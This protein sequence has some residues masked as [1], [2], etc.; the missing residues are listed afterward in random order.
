MLLISL[1]LI[2]LCALACFGL[3]RLVPTRRLGQGAAAISGLAGLL[4]LNRPAAVPGPPETLLTIG[5]AP[6]QLSASLPDLE[7]ALA[8]AALGGGALALLALASAI[9][10]KVRGFGAI[11]GW[12][13]LALAAALLGLA[14]PPLSLLQPLAWTCGVIAGYGAIWASGALARSEALPQGLLLGLIGSALLGGGLVGAEPALAAGELPEPALALCLLLAVL[15][16][17][18]LAPFHGAR[19]EATAAPAPLGALISGLV[20]PC[21]G[22]G[23]LIR[24][25]PLLP[26]VPPSWALGLGAL[27]LMGALGSAGGALGER[28]LR[29]LLAWLTGGQ[30]GLVLIAAGLS[31]PLAA[32]AG[33]ALLLTMM[34]ASVAGAA[35]IEPL[36]R[37]AGTDD[38]TSAAPG[39]PLPLAGLLWAGAVAALL[40]LP[41]FLGFWGQIWLL[42]GVTALLPWA[43]PLLLAAGVLRLLAAL[44]P[45]PRFW[46]PPRPD[47]A[48][49]PPGP[50]DVI[51]GAAALMPP[52]IFGLAPQVA[53]ALWLRA[54]PFAPAALPIADGQQLAATLGAALIALAAGLI[55]RAPSARSLSADPDE[56]PV[57][58]APDALARAARPLAWLSRPDGLTRLAWSALERASAGLRSAV[59]I[60]EQRYYLLAVLMVLIIMM[61]LMAL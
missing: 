44:A 17:G 54:A 31:D 24:A 27:G 1:S 47:L 48:A 6:L 29:P 14:A 59:A 51:V 36:E 12:G 40:G 50:I 42:D 53:W 26:V 4:L 37:S 18:G 60:F 3:S 45:L 35:A 41:P 25:M 61:L 15:M 56:E 46:A 34:L 33:P 55:A 38:Y 11:F 2:I 39:P 28:R 9:A 5:A 10:P 16:I 21:I 57:H 13:Q 19:G 22:L 8:L 20:L 49:A 52:L 43:A 7:Q 23:W 58:L 30:A 32:L